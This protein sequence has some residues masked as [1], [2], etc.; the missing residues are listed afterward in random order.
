MCAIVKKS[1]GL[2][3]NGISVMNRQKG[4]LQKEFNDNFRSYQV[5][6]PDQNYWLNNDMHLERAVE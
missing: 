1:L 4:Q 5:L 3:R 2:I 6:D